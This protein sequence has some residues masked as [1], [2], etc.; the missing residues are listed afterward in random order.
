MSARPTLTIGD[1]H[2]SSWSLRPWLALRVATPD[3]DTQLIR[4][5]RDDTAARIRAMSP[6]GKVP[7]LTDGDVVVWES[8]AIREYI[9][10]RVPEAQ[11]WPE[12]HHARGAVRHHGAGA[13]APA[14]VDAQQASP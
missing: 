1:R 10:E 2:L 9:A 11:R 4:L 13:A 12:G 14:H 3:F 5:R 6:G 7:V 8:L